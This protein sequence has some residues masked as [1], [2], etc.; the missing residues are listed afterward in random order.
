MI[1]EGHLIKPEV[2]EKYHQIWTDK[3]EKA[4]EIW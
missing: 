3:L 2:E 1:Q 4:E